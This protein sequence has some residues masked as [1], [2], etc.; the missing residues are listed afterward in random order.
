MKMRR[1][2]R[3]TQQNDNATRRT[4]VQ[5]PW[6]RRLR[7]AALLAVLA[8]VS[9]SCGGAADER[10]ADAAGPAAAGA[11]QADVD[12]TPRIV[13][14][15]D[16]LTAGLGV[17]PEQAYPAVL[18]ERLRAAG[19]D[20]EV[21]NAGV[22]G[23]TS[24]GGLR[25]LDWSLRGDV[26]LLVVALGANDGLRGLP[27]TEMEHNLATIIERAQARGIR[28]LLAGME[29]PP[30]FGPAY[31]ADFRRVYARLAARYHV[32]FIPFFLENVAGHAALNQADGIHPTA[33]GHR[34][35]ADRFWRELQPM[36]ADA[37]T[38]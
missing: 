29:A 28:V 33:E 9:A 26:R 7:A 5:W 32:A 27:P 11:P 22:S 18:Q 24:A 8:I 10:A 16:S 35:I 1:R 36:L 6:R 21:V 15:G 14:L 23:D 20:Y 12:R 34:A 30:N 19:L 38:R 4:A 2:S 3:V 37:S 25:R 13:C 31:T 17:A